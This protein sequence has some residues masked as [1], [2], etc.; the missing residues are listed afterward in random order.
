MT[1][2]RAVLPGQ[3]YMVTRRCTQRQFLMRPDDDTNQAFEYCLAV[4]AERTGIELLFT[5]AMSNHHHTGIHDPDGRYPEFLEYF[6]RLFAKCQNA[7]RGRWENFWSSEQ[8]SIVRLLSDHD[9][10]DKLIYA[11]TNPVKDQLVERVVDWPGVSSYR[12]NR[13]GE[14]KTIARPKHFFRDDGSMPEHVVLEFHRPKTFDSLSSE[15]WTA[16]LGRMIKEVEFRAAARRLESRTK[17]V[18]RAAIL[19]QRWQG[20][21]Q[22]IEPRRGLNPRVAAKS[23]WSRI[24]ALQRDKAFAKAYREARLLLA[25]GYNYV[26]FPDGAYWMMRFMAVVCWVDTFPPEQFAM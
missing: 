15:Q 22:S 18:G 9:V 11:V 24:E 3:N 13:T 8:T 16:L 1:Q 7:L 23:T 12:A 6:H 21:P 5:I 17:V 2:P 10:L 25:A 14:V 26:R 20:R 19:K 4:A